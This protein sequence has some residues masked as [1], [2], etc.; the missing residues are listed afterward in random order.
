MWCLSLWI[1]VS[2]CSACKSGLADLSPRANPSTSGTPSA[3]SCDTTWYRGIISHHSMAR[4]TSQVRGVPKNQYQSEE[5]STQTKPSLKFALVCWG[6]KVA[7]NQ[8]P[9]LRYIC[10]CDIYVIYI[11]YIYF[12]YI[13]AHWYILMY[14]YRS[15]TGHSVP[16][17]G[18]HRGNG[19]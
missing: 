19:V 8:E 9:A 4:F 17:P 15:W 1:T 7:L 10:I 18:K 2:C 5:L 11:S 13:Y 3:V 6:R 14:Q 16:E 12:I